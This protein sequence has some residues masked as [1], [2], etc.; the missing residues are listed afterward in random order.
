MA[1]D[2]DRNQ[3]SL[4]LQP[5]SKIGTKLSL[6]LQPSLPSH[7]CGHQV[8]P[9]SAFT[10]SP[11]GVGGQS[12]TVSATRGGDGDP[13]GHRPGFGRMKPRHGRLIVLV[14]L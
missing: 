3:V 7:D 9:R 13:G 10:E 1:N 8:D 2:K 6:M 12:G 5:P 14:E 11:E 4:M